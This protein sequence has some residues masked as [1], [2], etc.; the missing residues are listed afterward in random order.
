VQ[1]LPL[2]EKYSLIAPIW[3]RTAPTGIA[4]PV[5]LGGGYL[6][7]NVSE[8]EVYLDQ[9]RWLREERIKQAE[10]ASDFPQ[11]LVSPISLLSQNM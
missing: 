7:E 3:K 1:F 10:K 6:R 9:G 4:Q 2:L 5:D 8:T 11:C